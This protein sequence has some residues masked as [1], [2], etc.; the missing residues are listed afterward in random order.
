MLKNGMNGTFERLS[1]EEVNFFDIDEGIKPLINAMN[2]IDW[3]ITISCCEGHENK[4]TQRSPY[5]AFKCKSSK[6]NDLC[7]YLGKIEKRIENDNM[8]VM[9]D[10][11]VV[12]S[13]SV[14]GSQ[15]DMKKGWVSLNL[16]IDM[17]WDDSP[18]CKANL[19]DIMVSTFNER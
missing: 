11:S 1:E 13:P 2:R 19:F 5:V 14:Y 9:L 18:E 4:D 10:L 15:I 6:I 12:F 8:G 3:L 7:K 16:S 17:Y